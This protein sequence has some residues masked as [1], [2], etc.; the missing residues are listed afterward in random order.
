VSAITPPPKP[1]LRYGELQQWLQ[2][3][4]ISERKLS[5]LLALQIIKAYHLGTGRALYN[6]AEVQRDVLGK[7]ET[8]TTT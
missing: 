8:K 3:N 7:L 5:N 4:G 6:A 2:E 1:I